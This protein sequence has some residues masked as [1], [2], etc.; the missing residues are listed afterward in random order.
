MGADQEIIALIKLLD[1]DDPVVYENVTNR[2]ISYGPD[3]IPTLE[4]VWEDTF[5][6]EIHERIE[7]LIHQINFDSLFKEFESYFASEHASLKQ[8]AMLAAKLHYP[9]LSEMDVVLQL[10]KMKQ[11]IWLELHNNLTP[12]EQ[13]NVFN[14]IMYGV[15]GFGGSYSAKPDFKDY[16]I[17]NVLDSKNGTAISL[18]LIYLILAQELDLPVYG[19]RLHRHFVLS[20]Q[21]KAIHDFSEDHASDVIF[22]INAL[23]KGMIFARNEIKD[24]LKNLGEE[25]QL[26]YFSPSD[27][28]GLICELLSYMKGHHEEHN[29]LDKA[30]EIQRLIDLQE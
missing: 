20:Y 21:K 13:I 1:D 8:G 27:N 22:Y 10:D 4:N 29:N 28:K 7:T 12:L 15:L 25:M 19:V 26:H 6:P 3:V 5:N 9:D 17:N 23:N 2:L 18:G 11:K 30:N 14:Q 16:C 24:Y